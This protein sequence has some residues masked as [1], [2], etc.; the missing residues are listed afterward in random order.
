MKLYRV[1]SETNPDDTY[2]VRYFPKS[3]KFIWFICKCLDYKYKHFKFENY[4]C[5]HIAK[6]KKYLKEKNDK[7]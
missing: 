1:K 4:E 2:I 5:K 3:K 6:V 7:G